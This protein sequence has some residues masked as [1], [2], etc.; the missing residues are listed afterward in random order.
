MARVIACDNGMRSI[1]IEQLHSSATE[2]QFEFVLLGSCTVEHLRTCHYQ[3][4]FFGVT[5][6]QLLSGSLLRA[7]TLSTEQSRAE[8]N[9]AG[10]EMTGP[11]PFRKQESSLLHERPWMH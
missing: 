6:S 2:F 11:S 8:Q 7:I 5:S 3:A 4:I 1:C 9:R 10:Q